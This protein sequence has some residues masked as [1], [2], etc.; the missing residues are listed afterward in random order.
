MKC[1]QE[2]LKSEVSWRNTLET[3]YDGKGVLFVKYES[4]NNSSKQTNVNFFM[5][6][7]ERRLMAS[8]MTE[9]DADPSST[10]GGRLVRGINVIGGREGRG[11]STLSIWFA[12]HVS[13][14]SEL[15]G[16]LPDEEV[17]H[18]D[19]LIL[20]SEDN[21]GRTQKPRLTAA[22]A[23]HSRILY[24]DKS[25]QNLKELREL[26]AE[27]KQE[28]IRPTML[29]IDPVRDIPTGNMNISGVSTSGVAVISAAIDDVIDVNDIYMVVVQ[30][31]NKGQGQ[32]LLDGFQEGGWPK[33]A[34]S[35]LRFEEAELSSGDDVLGLWHAKT[36]NVEGLSDPLPMIIEGY[37][38]Y[39]DQGKVVKTSRIKALPQDQG[40]IPKPYEPFQNS[41][42]AE[43]IVKR[44]KVVQE[45]RDRVISFVSEEIN[46]DPQRRVGKKNI[47]SS[48]ST[49]FKIS[50][51]SARTDIVSLINCGK[52]VKSKDG[53]TAFL[54]LP[55][56][57][58]D[59]SDEYD[60]R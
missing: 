40:M 55:T 42:T 51:R 2:L 5:D 59:A 54:E 12:A 21:Y 52:L 49:K 27:W 19:V 48:I 8:Q 56:G 18:G 22:G 34:R 38:F 46:R 37:E 11:K 28:A 26:L 16:T 23:D 14:G 17:P 3:R 60:E 35:V 44:Q 7:G 31:T 53:V 36:N 4:L 41:R 13:S 33:K 25:I 47:E 6:K 30:H 20:S 45:R 24:Y 57:D 43:D 58:I 15:P 39:N 29:I 1:P 50:E 10:F 32:S 9:I